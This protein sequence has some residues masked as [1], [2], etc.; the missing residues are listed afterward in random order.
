MLLVLA[1]DGAREHLLPP[2]HAVVEQPLNA[3][4]VEALAVAPRE[5]PL[6]EGQGAIA[7]SAR[8]NGHHPGR[9]LLAAGRRGRARNNARNSTPGAAR[10]LVCVGSETS[11]ASR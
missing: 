4:V 8:A 6:P 5:H 7:R 10:T 2:Q 1:G 11:F 3:R 9:P